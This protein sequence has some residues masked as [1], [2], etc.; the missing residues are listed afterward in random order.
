MLT[1]TADNG[2]YCARCLDLVAN[3][4]AGGGEGGGGGRGSIF[5]EVNV[6][7]GPPC[8]APRKG[9]D[10]A[11]LPLADAD[12]P[13]KI[14]KLRLVG[15]HPTFQRNK[16][17]PLFRVVTPNTARDCGLPDWWPFWWSRIARL[18]R[19]LVLQPTGPGVAGEN[20]PW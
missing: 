18:A 6:S 10:Q 14:V 15:L 9:A 4:W 16:G 13:D 20:W 2:H 12:V 1:G 11:R 19:V 8:P 5:E 7:A 3:A 17:L